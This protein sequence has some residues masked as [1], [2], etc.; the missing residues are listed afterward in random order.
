LN[1][2]AVTKFSLCLFV[3]IVKFADNSF[4]WHFF[5]FYVA[6]DNNIAYLCQEE[7]FNH[8]IMNEDLLKMQSEMIEDLRKLVKEQ[9]LE[10]KYLVNTKFYLESQVRIL[11]KK[12][13]NQ[14]F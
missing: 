3:L 1:H 13:N 4:Y 12:N 8:Y 7:T 6:Y 14:I 11:Q 10:I 9:E 5:V 2:L